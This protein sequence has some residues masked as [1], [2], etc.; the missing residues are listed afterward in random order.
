MVGTLMF[1]KIKYYKRF[2]HAGLERDVKSLSSYHLKDFLRKYEPSASTSRYHDYKPVW[3]NK[4]EFNFL[5]STNAIQKNVIKRLYYDEKVRVGI[6]A[7][8]SMKKSNHVLPDISVNKGSKQ[9]S[10]SQ[11]RLNI[12]KR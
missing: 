4:K 2:E 10:M 11:M 6:G 7:D 8:A 9:N 5:R 3:M 1:C 12:D